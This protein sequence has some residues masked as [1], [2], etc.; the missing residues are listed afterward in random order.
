M[1]RKKHYSNNNNYNSNLRIV[2][3]SSVQSNSV[4]AESNVHNSEK[5]QGE[6]IATYTYTY[7]YIHA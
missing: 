4:P 3:K 6:A 2:N 1:I 5:G 7:I